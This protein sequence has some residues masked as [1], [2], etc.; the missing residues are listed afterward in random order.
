MPSSVRRSL[1]PGYT[2]TRRRTEDRAV[3]A[4]TRQLRR[5]DPRRA[6]HLDR[7]TLVRAPQ[8]EVDL[9]IRGRPVVEGVEER[10][11]IAVGA[12]KCENPTLQQVPTFFHRHRSELSLHRPC[13]SGVDPVELRMAALAHP[14][15][16]LERAQAKGQQ[17]VFE[18]VEVTEHRRARHAGIA[19]QRRRIDDLCVEQA[20]HGEEARESRKVA[21]Q[22]FGLDL[23]AQVDAYIGAQALL[24][25]GGRPDQRNRAEAQSALEVEVGSQLRRRQRK[26]RPPRRPA[27]EQVAAGRFQ[28]PGARAQQ[29]E[30]QPSL[31]DEPAH[32][33]Q[34][35][36]QPLHLVG[37]HPRAGPQEAQRIPE[38]RGVAQELVVAPLVEEIEACGIGKIRARPGALAGAADAE[39]KEAVRRNRQETRVIGCH[40]AVI[41]PTK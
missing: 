28:F 21:H 8:Q 33:V 18:D 13:E 37:D 24:G 20:G 39:E 27:G 4:Q 6:L 30:P 29:G 36:R 11:H 1:L 25:I 19:R 31:L 3:I 35:R 5:R 32:R 40:V 7:Q 23:L 26:E 2:S 9:H 17:G 34:Q 16:P 22:C 12:Q 41:M 14:Q 10:P 38:G 15:S